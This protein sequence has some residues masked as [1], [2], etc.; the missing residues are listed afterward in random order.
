MRLFFN[1]FFI[2]LKRSIRQPVNLAMLGVL[3][4]L[5]VVYRQIPASEKSLYL[6]VAILSEDTDPD[7]QAVVNDLCSANSIFHFYTV[8]SKEEMYRDISS[9]KANSGMMIP[10]GF[11]ENAWTTDTP[12]K[13]ITFTSQASSLPSLCRDEFFNRFYRYEAPRIIK[14][15]MKK[16]DTYRAMDQAQLYA[17]TDRIYQKLRNDKEIFRVEDASGGVYNELTREEKVEIPVRKLAGLFILT[18]GLLGIATFL[19][20]SEERLYLRL[21]GGE[22]YYMRL[23]HI[24]SCILPMA[25]ISWPVLW[26]TEGGN[27]AALLG[28]VGLYT[29]VCIAYSL[30]F[31]LILRSSAVYQKVLPIL[32]TMAIVFGGIL[33][34]VTSFDR[35][36]K[37]ISMCLPTYYF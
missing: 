14:E 12:V 15:L 22:R 7:M 20:D 2:L 30:F 5:A 19:K 34:D 35:T 18:A 36:F 33:F 11:M 24:I 23:I 17:L 1:R 32:L 9:G 3:L 26:I 25:V 16:S 29:L 28:Q 31:S 37:A 4:L 13:V 27:G 10:A 21:R 8:E 6:P